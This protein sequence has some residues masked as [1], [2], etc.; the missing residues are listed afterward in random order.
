[1]A[2]EKSGVQSNLVAVS[3]RRQNIAEK[4]LSR[5]KERCEFLTKEV[6]DY[7]STLKDQMQ[8]REDVLTELKNN[9]LSEFQKNVAELT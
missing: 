3:K 2:E 5:L 4:E 8:L 6:E 9:F 7:S 1:M